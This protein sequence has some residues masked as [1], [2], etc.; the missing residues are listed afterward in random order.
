[1]SVIEDRLRAAVHAAADTVAVNS[2]PPLRLTV[3]PSRVPIPHRFTRG[4]G[5]WHAFLAPIAAATAV[6]AV[7]GVWLVAGTAGSKPAP[8]GGDT[9]TYARPGPDGVP[10]DYLALIPTPA[11]HDEFGIGQSRFQAAV[12]DTVSGAVLARATTP[13][14]YSTFVAVTGAADDQTFVLAAERTPSASSVSGSRAFFLAQYD[15]GRRTVT[16]TA[17]PIPAISASTQLDGLALSPSG[18]RL[19]V[20]TG[21]HV[22]ISIY[23]V[24][25][26]AVLTVWRQPASTQAY[27]LSF[28]SAGQLAFFQ[29][30]SGI[31]LLYPKPSAGGLIS[32]FS[33][34]A[35]RPP[36]RYRILPE[37][38]IA[39]DGKTIVTP[40]LRIS[41]RRNPSGE[42]A[43]FSAATGKLAQVLWP[44]RTLGE[45]LLWSSPSGSALV[46]F[47]PP[48]PDGAGVN[49]RFG[50]LRDGRF[51]SLPDPA[52]LAV[53]TTAL[54]LIPLLAF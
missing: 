3:Q 13:A 38:L 52:P 30:N 32:T 2:V 36:H 8:R 9:A 27:N 33:R 21:R 47:A 46:V 43:K 44:T 11:G 45:G 1:M 34:L 24:A 39:L 14:H 7:V 22:Q 25:T 18:T 12:I 53:S 48:R 17:L 28:D 42:L 4:G 6:I 50:V 35:A 49:D 29:S 26:G 54:N 10:R 16:L 37:A 15:P 23:S 51:L 41:G 5:R 31:W 19:A 20:S 40:L